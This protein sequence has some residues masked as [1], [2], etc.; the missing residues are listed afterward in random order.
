MGATYNIYKI[1]RGNRSPISQPINQNTM[2]QKFQYN[3]GGRSDA[4]YKGTAGDCG[5]RAIAIVTGLSYQQVYDMVNSLEKGYKQRKTGKKSN[6]REGIW[7][8]DAKRIMQNLGFKWVATMFIG[9][10]C[11]THLRADE[12]P[13]GKILCQ[14][15]KHYTA[16]IN[17]VI[18]DTY[19]CSRGGTRC[20][21]GYFIKEN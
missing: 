5:V 17:G 10:G 11:K 18:N 9:Q 1:K 20:V 15:S 13:T 6:A 8:K 16:V 21:Y 19:D 12:L 4:G 14:V 3:D 7:Q 2:N